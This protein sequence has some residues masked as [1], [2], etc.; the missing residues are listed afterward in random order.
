MATEKNNP[1]KEAKPVSI[2]EKT[3]IFYKTWFRDERK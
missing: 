3:N 1:P 2:L